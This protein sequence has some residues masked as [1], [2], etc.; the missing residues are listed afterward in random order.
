MLC[1]K[2]KVAD[3]TLAT[4]ARHG[5]IVLAPLALKSILHV[6]KLHVNLLFIPKITQNLNCKVI[7]FSFSL[8]VSG[9]YYGEDDWA[10]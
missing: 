7:F 6:P 9:K 3:G 8:C 10:C 5:T 2:I 4:V 1:Q